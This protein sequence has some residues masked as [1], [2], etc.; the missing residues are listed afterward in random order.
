[1]DAGARR[2][3]ETSSQETFE[4]VKNVATQR[5]FTGVI[6]CSFARKLILWLQVASRLSAAATVQLNFSF[7]S[8]VIKQDWLCFSGVNNET[9]RSTALLYSC[10][11]GA[12][13]SCQL[14]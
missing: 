12:I 6:N 7:I 8:S 1:M 5:E 4:D 13:Q 11:R 9:F 10:V 2:E 3:A 14:S